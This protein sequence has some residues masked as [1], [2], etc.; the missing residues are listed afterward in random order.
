MEKLESFV[1]TIREPSPVRQGVWESRDVNVYDSFEVGQ[2]I[3][4][5][6]DWINS[7]KDQLL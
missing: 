3:N 1:R 4:E 7:K 6:I 5:I 2:K